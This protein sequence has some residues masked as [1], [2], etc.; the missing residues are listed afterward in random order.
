MP[1]CNGVERLGVG[2][3]NSGSQHQNHYEDRQPIFGLVHYHLELGEYLNSGVQFLSRAV[4]P[5][6][7]AATVP[8][9]DSTT[10]RSSA[11][12]LLGSTLGRLKVYKGLH[13]TIQEY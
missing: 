5:S 13:H 12:E 8:I 7:G 4:M 11:G 2:A 9:Q 1:S 6:L 10:Q 3:P